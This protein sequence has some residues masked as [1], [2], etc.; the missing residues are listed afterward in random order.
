MHDFKFY[1]AQFLLTGKVVAAL[2]G[3]EIPKIRGFQTFGNYRR[4]LD[5]E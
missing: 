3:L 1:Y 5:D 4:L 2:Q